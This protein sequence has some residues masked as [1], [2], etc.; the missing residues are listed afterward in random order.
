LAAALTGGGL[1]FCQV[2]FI[3]VAHF[4]FCA[5]PAHRRNIVSRNCDAIPGYGK[6]RA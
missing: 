3:S 5:I 2:N 1:G 4:A 6:R